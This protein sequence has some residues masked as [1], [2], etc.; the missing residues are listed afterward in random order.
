MAWPGAGVV[1]LLWVLLATLGVLQIGRLS[2][3]MADASREWGA[4]VPDPSAT[5]HMCL[6]AYVYA[7][8][9]SRRGVDNLYDAKWYPIFDP[10]GPVCRLVETPIAGLPPWTADAYQYPPPFLLLP[11]VA[12]ALTHSY[13]VIR[14]GW[15]LIQSLL[16][17]GGA[18][19]AA[20]WIGGPEGIVVGLL[21]PALLASIE[22]M[23]SLQF[24]Q[25]HMV[26]VMLACGAMI[27]FRAARR[28]WRRAAGRGDPLQIS[29]AAA[30]GAGCQEEWRALG[31]TAAF[32]VAFS[33]VGL[34]ILGPKPYAAFFGY[35]LPRIA[36]GA[37]FAFTHLGRNAVFL[38]S[39]N[40]SIEALGAKLR[41]LDQGPALL[42][43]ARVV[44]WLY[45]MTVLMLAVLAARAP[46]TRVEHLLAWLALLN[47]A[48]LRSAAPSM[49]VM[50]P[51]LW[52]LVLWPRR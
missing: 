49:Y 29:R 45:T 5:H 10:P 12:I 6:S 27:A 13:D 44:T 16:F 23:M 50:A 40:F 11:R 47:L 31:W 28:F 52:M 21:I 33:L 22:P 20:R 35:Q 8:D 24:G 3:F 41:L 39:R 32:A 37:A 25:F 14:A 18:L 9:L 30:R 2:A 34:A 26:A 1:S 43:M 46:R 42:A 36:S 48:A 19:L 15:F 38:T 17:I 4:T 51:V 7:A